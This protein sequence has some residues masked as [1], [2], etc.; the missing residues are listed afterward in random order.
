MEHI[1]FLTLVWSFTVKSNIISFRLTVTFSCDTPDLLF[2]RRGNFL[3]VARQFDGVL[4]FA[5]IIL[6]WD[7]LVDS[8]KR[9]LII[10]RDE[11]GTYTP[12]INL[13]SLHFQ[14]QN[15]WLVQVIWSIDF[16]I[17]KA[18]F[19][20]LLTYFFRD[21][22][23]ISRVNAD[24]LEINFVTKFTCHT[25]SCGNTNVQ[26]IICIHK[27]NTIFMCLCISFKSFIIVAIALN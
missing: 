13:R 24:T 27:E 20:Q 26:S 12:N 3:C 5:L 10:S 14:V 25:N 4:H 6:H 8:T 1:D 2:P 19:I 18:S 22:G 16:G 9:R 11:L 15:C 21:I 7:E 17:S 23:H